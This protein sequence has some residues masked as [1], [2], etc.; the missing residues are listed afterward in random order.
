[1]T[2]T[3]AWPT[4]IALIE[5]A[6]AA[7]VLSS[8]P[9]EPSPDDEGVTATTVACGSPDS[10][11]TALADAAAADEPFAATE[12]SATCAPTLKSAG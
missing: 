6:S 1:M 7:S 4:G 9:A 10:G 3:T 12:E 2:A 5:A 11:V 8:I